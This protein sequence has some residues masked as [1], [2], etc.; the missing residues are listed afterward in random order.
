MYLAGAQLPAGTYYYPSVH[1]VDTLAGVP[2]ALREYPSARVLAGGSNVVVGDDGVPE[3]VL[4]MHPEVLIL[5]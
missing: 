1:I 4:L 2:E 3:P 5:R